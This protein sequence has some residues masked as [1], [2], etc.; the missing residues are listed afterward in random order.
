MSGIVLVHG[1]WSA[2]WAWRDFREQLTRDG[3]TVFAPTLTGVGERR[4]LLTRKIEL[5][6]HIQDICEVL[7][8]EDLHD[9]VLVGHSY[10]GMVITGA[11]DRMP[12]RVRHLVYVDAFCPTTVNA[13]LT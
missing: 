8:M 11:A 5:E 2:A 3:T 9:V 12:A 1:A 10:G 4:H 7:F 6:D 13:C